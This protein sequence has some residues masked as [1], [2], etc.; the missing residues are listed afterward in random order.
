[1]KRVWG[2]LLAVVTLLAGGVV[3]IAGCKHDDST[4]FVQD[5][6]AAQPVS[7]GEQC[8]F[9]SD[10]TQPFISSGVLDI[11]L[12]SDYS[13]TY[14]IGNQ[15]VPEVNSQQL[16]TETNIIQVQGAVVR[17]TDSSGNQLS[18]FTRLAAATVYPSSGSVP[19]YAPIT[20]TTVDEGT[21]QGDAE[22][23]SNVTHGGLTRLVTYVTF[24][25]QT[26]GGNAIQSGEF[27]FPVDVCYACLIG[28]SSSSDEPNTP[29][30]TFPQPNCTF[31]REPEARA[32]CHRPACRGR[33]SESTARSA[34]AM[35]PAKALP[36]GSS[37]TQGPTE[38]CRKGRALMR[39]RFTCTFRTRSVP[40]TEGDLSRDAAPEG[41]L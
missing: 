6:L 26:T 31:L 8:T 7:A 29:T 25:G 28:F 18:T 39:A 2:H 24:F 21:I 11:A 10:P 13:P 15:S 3:A 38:R 16:Q 34:G 5:V 33:T 4:L 9:T 41:R 27:E 37:R 23:Q 30:V 22:L 19:G 1:M 32:P 17:I 20:V 14:L 36:L 35:P 12:R 40:S